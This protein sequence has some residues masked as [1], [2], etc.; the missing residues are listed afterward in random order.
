M[1]ILYPDRHVR[2]LNINALVQRARRGELFLLLEDGQMVNQIAEQ[3][4]VEFVDKLEPGSGMTTDVVLA[5]L[6]MAVDSQHDT[7][8]AMEPQVGFITFCMLVYLL[9][10]EPVELHME[11]VEPVES[12][13]ESMES[14]VEP[15]VEPVEPVK[16]V[17]A[18][19]PFEDLEQVSAEVAAKLEGKHTMADGVYL[20]VKAAADRVLGGIPRHVRLLD[21]KHYAE[22]VIARRTGLNPLQHMA[23]Y[24]FIEREKVMARRISE[25]VAANPTL[26]VHVVIGACH[27]TG[28]L[29][30]EFINTLNVNVPSYMDLNA[31]IEQ[32]YPGRRLTNLIGEHQVC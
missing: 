23:L 30:N 16:P 15:H 28:N 2:P 18:R 19:Q 10:V 4:C 9:A 11:P 24:N 12:V 21:I 6:V 31:L 20:A 8:G 14:V 13:A 5:C 27:V 29:S 7:I 25:A 22:R 3:G 26:D 17:L 1:I 32:H